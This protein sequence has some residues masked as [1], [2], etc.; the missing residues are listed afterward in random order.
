[1]SGSADSGVDDGDGAG[2]CAG[3]VQRADDDGLP[4]HAAGLPPPP[5][6]VQEAPQE[7]EEEGRRRVQLQFGLGLGLRDRILPRA[8]RLA[9]TVHL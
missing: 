7:E 5:Q 9:R 3:S 6:E 4:G 8:E 2:E 1:V